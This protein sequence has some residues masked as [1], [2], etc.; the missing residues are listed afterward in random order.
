MG[1]LGSLESYSQPWVAWEQE[2]LEAQ[3]N[4]MLRGDWEPTFRQFWTGNASVGKQAVLDAGGFD[5][6]FP[7]AEDVELARRLHERGLQFRFNPRARGLHHAERSLAA[8]VAMHKSYGSLEVRIFRALGESHLVEILADN[9]SH[10]HPLS[11]WLVKRCLGRAL[12]REVASRALSGYLRLAEAAT[13]PLLTNQVCGALAN[14][15]YWDASVTTM[16]DELAER[17][18]TRG[19][20]LLR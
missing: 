1:P 3:Y 2:K 7:R 4:A 20:E 18:F 16:G 9:W 10:V 11:R 8:W 14:L 6:T 17:V 12:P 19:D 13:V 5:P 15:S